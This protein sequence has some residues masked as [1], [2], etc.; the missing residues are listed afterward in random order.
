MYKT[1][2]WR[3]QAGGRSWSTADGGHGE[4]GLM[5]YVHLSIQAGKTLS[6]MCG[7]GPP[8]WASPA[9]GAQA[10][11]GG[12]R[13]GLWAWGCAAGPPAAACCTSAPQGCLQDRCSTRDSEE[14]ES[15]P[16]KWD[17]IACACHQPRVRCGMS[18]MGRDTTV[19]NRTLTACCLPTTGCCWQQDCSPC[20]RAMHAS[21]LVCIF[22]MWCGN[23]PASSWHPCPAEWTRCTFA[24]SCIASRC[25][26]LGRCPHATDCPLAC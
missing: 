22:S 18:A 1:H 17:E 8:H 2:R 13:A 12:C 25:W 15:C 20:V 16:R 19:G 6:W 3:P 26:D 14:E 23:G 10:L 24:S 11:R 5:S 21:W 4:G 9:L 7:P